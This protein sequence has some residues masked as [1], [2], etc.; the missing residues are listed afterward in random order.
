MSILPGEIID[1]EGNIT[2]GKS[3]IGKYLEEYLNSIGKKT[4]YYP[5][6]R[7]E[8]KLMEY[9]SDMKKYGYSFQMHMLKMRL[10]LL[11]QALKDKEE[12]YIVILD[13]NLLGDRIFALL[14]VENKNMTDEEYDNYLKLS[15]QACTEPDLII[16]LKSDPYKSYERM[17]KRKTDGKGYDLEYM[18]KLHELHEQVINETKDTKIMITSF[19]EDLMNSLK[20]TDTDRAEE[21]WKLIIA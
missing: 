3:T 17:K 16:Y 14:Q 2:S 13:R 12:G 10:D 20:P 18:I 19:M 11:K 5:E 7:D 1:L 6:P 8:E 21:F 9:I 15:A 4:K